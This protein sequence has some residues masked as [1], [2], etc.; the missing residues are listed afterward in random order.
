MI[1]LFS[2]YSDQ[3]ELN[4]IKSVLDS[5]WLA[6]GP[7]VK[8]F[9]ELISKKLGVKHV[10]VCSSC[11]TALH[12]ALLGV[13]V[14]PGDDVL[15]ADYTFPATGHAVA[16]CQANPVFVDVDLQTYNLDLGDAISK[17]TSKTKAIIPVHTF[18]Q[19]AEMDDVMEF[20]S[21]ND[22]YVIE[23][24]ACAFGSKYKGSMAGTIGDVG[25]FSFH[26]TKGITTGEGGCVVTD[27]DDIAEKV[28]SLIMFGSGKSASWE[29]DKSNRFSIPTFVNIGFNYKMSDIAAAC[30]VAQMRKLDRIIC[31]KRELASY[32]DSKLKN[33]PYIMAPYVEPYNYHNYQGYCTL[34]DD[35]I[36]RDGV[37]QALKDK[38][39]GSQIGTYS[40]F[41]QPV[42]NSCYK[43]PTSLD[44][45]NR[46]LR[47]PLYYELTKSDIDIVVHELK[48][49]IKRKI[50]K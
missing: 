15:V 5:N 50:K 33:V 27:N 40:S 30:G 25:C 17:L 13:G 43:C 21:N 20:A 29:R 22:L 37:I 46:A 11:T 36:D 8:E 4:E 9:E 1:P 45:Y 14:A 31:R 34:V 32:L 19:V 47:L 26:A 16:H 49:I 39:I 42:Y 38:G 6:Q 3:D 48:K 35:S 24:A 28:Q 7:K 41:I 12:L 23:D 10:I 2:P 18:G 44:I